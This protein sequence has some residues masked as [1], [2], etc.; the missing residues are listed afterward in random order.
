MLKYTHLYCSQSLFTLDLIEEFLSK[1]TVPSRE[2]E[3][4]GKEEGVKEEEGE[5][6]EEGKKWQ[7]NVNYVSEYEMVGGTVPEIITLVWTF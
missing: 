1:R 2:T 5:R 4:E 6:K 7:K 3:G